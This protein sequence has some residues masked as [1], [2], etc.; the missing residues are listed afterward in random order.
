[1]QSYNG[2]CPLLAIANV[3]ILRGELKIHPDYSNVTHD[4]L[5]SLVADVVNNCEPGFERKNTL[6]EIANLRIENALILL[7]RLNQGLDVNV[8]FDE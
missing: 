7:T 3:L 4:L 8:K 6:A 2:P 5:I 1:M